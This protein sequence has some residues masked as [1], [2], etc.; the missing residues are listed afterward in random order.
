MPLTHIDLSTFCF[1]IYLRQENNPKVTVRAK[2]A[3]AARPGPL[4]SI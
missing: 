2:M 3:L 4:Q 1:K